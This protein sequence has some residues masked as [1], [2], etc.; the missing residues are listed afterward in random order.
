MMPSIMAKYGRTT[1]VVSARTSTNGMTRML[2]STSRILLGLL[3]M[4]SFPFPNAIAS[5]LPCGADPM[6]DAYGYP[7]RI[8]WEGA[9]Q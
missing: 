5:P 2:R 8:L 3:T 4:P 9:L 7:V 1:V 6:S